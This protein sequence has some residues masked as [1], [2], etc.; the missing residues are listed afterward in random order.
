MEIARLYGYDKIPSRLPSFTPQKTYQLEKKTV[1]LENEI[2]KVLCGI[3]L[4][5]IMTYSLTSRNSMEH[6]GVSLENLVSLKNPMSSQQEIMR[7]SLLS[8]MLEVLN[9][10][11]NRKNTLLQL[12][13]LNKVYIMNKSTGQA[14]E[15]V[16]LSIGVCGNKPGN[17]K[18]KPRDLDLFDLKGIIEI[19]MEYLGVRGYRIEKAEHP[20]LKENMATAINVNGKACGVFGEVKEDVAR[21]FDIKRKVY[22]AEIAID[23]IL[24]CADLKKT[25]AALPKYPSIKRDIAILLDDTISASSIYDVIKEEAREFVKSVDVFDLYK[26]QQIQQG[27]KSLAY[28]I[29]YRSDERTLND[30]EVNDTHKKVQDA[31]TKRLGAQIR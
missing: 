12:F 26:G 27:K 15:T 9:W 8:E 23:D 29:E 18:E 25:F 22:V 6:L 5:E 21:R 1:T 11:L 13:E 24:G 14:E 19:L 20:S 7:P 17:W 30:K 3:G 28:T 16:H 4:N 31:L 10:N 2:R